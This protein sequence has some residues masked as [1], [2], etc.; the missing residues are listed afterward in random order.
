MNLLLTSNR[1]IK[2]H[3]RLYSQ[4]QNVVCLKDIKPKK[5][6]ISEN[7]DLRGNNRATL[8]FDSDS[9]FHF[10]L[11]GQIPELEITWCAMR[12]LR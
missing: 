12:R 5:V 11:G 6:E 4:H 10:Q 7:F 1:K 8:Q 2:P 3:F 9:R